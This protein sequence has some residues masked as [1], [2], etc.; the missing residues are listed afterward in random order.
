MLRRC[1]RVSLFCVLLLTAACSTAR[2]SDRP[3]R[4]PAPV[5]SAPPPAPA[6]AAEAAPKL[7]VGEF[8]VLVDSD[9]VGG[10][11]VLNG[12][13]VGRTPQRIVLSGTARGFCRE[14]VSIKVRFVAA[15]TDHTSQTVEEL[16]TPLDKIP[17]NVHFTLAGAARVAR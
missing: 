13:P 8:A 4:A 12:V 17:A 5:K 9:P 7:G 11:V 6:T 3:L 15:D 1:S 16:L 2:R 10:I 14:D